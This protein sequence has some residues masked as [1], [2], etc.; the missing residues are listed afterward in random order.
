MLR[1]A[2]SVHVSADAFK[3]IE[4]ATCVVD[5]SVAGMPAP[6]ISSLFHSW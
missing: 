2:C 6:S 5:A 4:R 3:Y 1:Q